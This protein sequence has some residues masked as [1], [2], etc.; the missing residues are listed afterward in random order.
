MILEITNFV[1]D[2]LFPHRFKKYLFFF[3]Q[4]FAF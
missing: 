1:K 2:F 3:E 4:K